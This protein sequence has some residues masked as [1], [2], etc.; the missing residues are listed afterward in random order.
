MADNADNEQVSCQEL[1]IEVDGFC[2]P[3]REQSLKSEEKRIRQVAHMRE[4]TTS[5]HVLRNA[6][7]ILGHSVIAYSVH[8]GHAQFS[9]ISMV[10][11]YI[12]TTAHLRGPLEVSLST[13]T[14]SSPNKVVLIWLAPKSC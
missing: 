2:P 12:L 13:N 7:G 6:W 11:H 14:G 1:E 4:E 8:L 3:E 5:F 10:H 9:Y